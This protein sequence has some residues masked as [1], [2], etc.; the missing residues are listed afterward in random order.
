MELLQLKDMCGVSGLYI[1]IKSRNEGFSYHLKNDH[2]ETG[3]EMC[4]PMHQS[5]GAKGGKEK[6]NET[7]LIKLKDP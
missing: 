3:K 4:F 6:K 7:L 1:L 5:T 2:A